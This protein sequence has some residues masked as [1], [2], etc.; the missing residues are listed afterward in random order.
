M[1][2]CQQRRLCVASMQPVLP[3]R[4]WFPE[5]AE[6]GLLFKCSMGTLDLESPAGLLERGP[7]QQPSLAHCTCVYARRSPA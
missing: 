7:P 3:R 2:L 1:Y 5:G 4:C 6:S